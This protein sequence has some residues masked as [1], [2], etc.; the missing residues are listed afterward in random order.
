MLLA[1]PIIETGAGFPSALSQLGLCK[2]AFRHA[3]HPHRQIMLIYSKA[4]F[5]EREASPRHENGERHFMSMSM[6]SLVSGALSG[7][8][9]FRTPPQGR[10]EKCSLVGAVKV[11]H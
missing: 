9:V 3:H 5:L 2:N 6:S 11:V 4:A 1:V 10:A 8:L 7:P